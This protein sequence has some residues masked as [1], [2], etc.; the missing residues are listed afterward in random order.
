[1]LIGF[2]G[3]PCSGKSTIAVKIFANLKEL[4]TKSE[5]IVE[6]ARQY[7]AKLRYD[8]Q[9]TRETPIELTDK[10]Q[11][12]IARKQ[13]E[14]EQWMKHSCGPTTIIVSDSSVLNTMLYIE[15]LTPELYK[16]FENAASIYD[17]LFFC[18]PINIKSLPDDP[19]R[20]HNLEEIKALQTQSMKILSLIKRLS[21]PVH[22][23]PGT[24]SLE[25]RFKEACSV[26]LNKHV[27]LVQRGSF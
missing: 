5:L 7:I 8:N 17:L 10:D 19:N 20:V 6:Q 13:I 11:T 21:I 22:E 12:N 24:M 4:N 16:F 23:L 18:H 2:I 25:A 27:E 15:K 1:M 26:T 3:A 14:I 9:L